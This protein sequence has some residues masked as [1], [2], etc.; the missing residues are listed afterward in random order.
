MFQIDVFTRP[1]FIDNAHPE[2]S[3]IM[4][5]GRTIPLPLRAP[6]PP[7]PAPR[8]SPPRAARRVV[9][10]FFTIFRTTWHTALG[11]RPGRACG[12]ERQQAVVGDQADLR[13][14]TIERTGYEDNKSFESHIANIP[15]VEG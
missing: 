15:H 8:R 7:A 3:R 1:M 12:D 13:T 10:C 4:S 5:G 6:G 2:L 14:E 9:R 11:T